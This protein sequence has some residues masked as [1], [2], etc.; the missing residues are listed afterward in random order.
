LMASNQELQA[1]NDEL[2]STTEELDVSRQEM[3]SVNEELSAVN[4]ELSINLEDLNRANSDLHN[5]MNATA[6]PTVFL[7][8]ELK[9][10]RYTP[11]AVNLFRLIPSDVGRPLADLKHRLEYLEML[12]DAQRVLDGAEP[13][14]REVRKETGKWFL[15]CPTAR[16]KNRLPESCSPS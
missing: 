15:S 11:A 14:E 7:D 3:Q 8:R 9:I 16:R 1:I 5:L 12:N 6:I 4:Q 2:R 13:I 10:M